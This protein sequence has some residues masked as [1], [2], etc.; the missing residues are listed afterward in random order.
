MF[1]WI[2]KVLKRGPPKELP[3]Y[4]WGVVSGPFLSEE[5]PDEDDNP[6]GLVMMVMKVSQ[7]VD[8]FEAEFWFDDL[9]DAYKLV[10]HFHKTI[11]PIELNMQEFSHDQ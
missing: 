8:V 5:L 4:L 6:D 3:I 11:S 10:S 7:G 1:S 2:N 9:K